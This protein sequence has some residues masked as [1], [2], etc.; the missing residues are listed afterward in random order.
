MK[1]KDKFIFPNIKFPVFTGFKP[2][3]CYIK[4]EFYEYKNL[5]SKFLIVE[6]NYCFE[7]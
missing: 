6:K 4:P 3:K 1:K 7:K 2:S 5:S